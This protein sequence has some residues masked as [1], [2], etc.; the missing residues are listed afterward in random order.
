[1]NRQ[2]RPFFA[3]LVLAFGASVVLAGQTPKPQT[4]PDNTKTNKTDIAKPTA[5][6]QGQNRSDVEITQQIRK[7]VTGDKTLSTAARNIKIVTQ[8]GKVTLS[9][10]V[11]S[12]DEKK[13]IE[14][15]ATQIAGAGHVMNQMQIAA[16]QPD[17]KSP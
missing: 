17:K 10:P 13:S 3:V 16:K 15:K 11:N 2:H 5:D 4:P 8:S 6:Q 14:T 7:L 12:E 9:G 1:M